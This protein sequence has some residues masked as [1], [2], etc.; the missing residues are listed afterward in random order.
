MGMTVPVVSHIHMTDRKSFEKDVLTAIY[1]PAQFQDDPPRPFDP[2][3]TIVHREA[4]RIIS[5]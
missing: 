1:L 3:I 4:L 5:R 2:D